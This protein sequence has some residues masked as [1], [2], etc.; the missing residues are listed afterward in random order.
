M[1]AHYNLARRMVVTT[2]WVV[3]E[4]LRIQ[5]RGVIV[6]FVAFN[7]NKMSEQLKEI[8]DG[9]GLKRQDLNCKC[10]RQIRGR[11]ADE[12]V[13]DWN[14]VGRTLDVS[15][16]TAIKY[17]NV[18]LPR[19]QDKAVEMLDAWS[20]E[21]GIKATCLKLAEALLRQ[22]KREVVEILCEEIS[23]QKKKAPEAGSSGTVSPHQQGNT[24]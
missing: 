12:I 16:L 8:L 9:F 14:H 18:T 7:S 20:V 6:V 4:T 21:Y 5:G 13:D 22:K 19:P 3:S 17:D 23:N 24:V 11:I 10:E 15:K 2:Q 1:R